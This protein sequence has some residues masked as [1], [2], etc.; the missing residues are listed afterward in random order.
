MRIAQADKVIEGRFREHELAPVSEII[1]A[2][3]AMLEA[4]P[5]SGSGGGLWP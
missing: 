5:A 2:I 3:T 1:Q 4:E